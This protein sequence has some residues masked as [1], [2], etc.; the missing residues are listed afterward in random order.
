MH[1]WISGGGGGACGRYCH[2]DHRHATRPTSAFALLK[3]ILDRPDLR[4]KMACS[5]SDELTCRTFRTTTWIMHVPRLSCML[6]AL[7]NFQEQ[8]V[9]DLE[10]VNLFTDSLLLEDC[11]FMAPG[12]NG[13]GLMTGRLICARGMNRCGICPPGICADINRQRF[14]AFLLPVAPAMS[15]IRTFRS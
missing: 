13:A 6:I 2:W 7:E 15:L 1:G 9:A 3:P 14:P 5:R 8:G 11:A 4:S 10:G 12:S